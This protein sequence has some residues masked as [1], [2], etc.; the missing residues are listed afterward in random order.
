M[1]SLSMLL[2]AGIGVFYG[3]LDYRRKKKKE[4]NPKIEETEE[5][6]LTHQL[7]GGRNMK[8]G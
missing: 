4:K 2:S 5:S 1:F 6:D 7:L 8:V 3:I